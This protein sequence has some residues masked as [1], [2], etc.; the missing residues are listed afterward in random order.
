MRFLSRLTL[1]T[2][3]WVNIPAGEV[4]YF[5]NNFDLSENS[6]PTKRAYGTCFEIFS[7]LVWQL[8]ALVRRIIMFVDTTDFLRVSGR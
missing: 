6:T 7:D 2:S 8:I 4:C 5:L 1:G 3:R